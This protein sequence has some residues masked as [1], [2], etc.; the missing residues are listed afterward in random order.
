MLCETLPA[1]STSSQRG[2]GKRLTL[3]TNHG[4]SISHTLKLAELACLVAGYTCR[5]CPH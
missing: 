3:N 2:K 5:E 4:V 1:P